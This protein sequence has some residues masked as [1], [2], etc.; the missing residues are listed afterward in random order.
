MVLF[1]IFLKPM[2]RGC[3][4]YVQEAAFSGR[5]LQPGLG[6]EVSHGPGCGLMTAD[7]KI[8][9]DPQLALELLKACVIMTWCPVG[10]PADGL[11]RIDITV[12]L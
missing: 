3:V 1:D 6:L 8:S 11:R 5:N 4:I 7:R 12:L 2:T 10:L 9:T